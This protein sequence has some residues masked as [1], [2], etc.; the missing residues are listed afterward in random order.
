MFG[1]SSEDVALSDVFGERLSL[2]RFIVYQ[3]FHSDGYKWC[4]IVVV[5]A[6]HVGVG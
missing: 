5:M 1:R 4:D 3:I 6:I 2:I